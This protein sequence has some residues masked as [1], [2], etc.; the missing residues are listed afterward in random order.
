MASLDPRRRTMLLNVRV[1][2]NLTLLLKADL[3]STMIFR[4]TFWRR[5]R[6][7]K[8]KICGQYSTL[9][10]NAGQSFCCTFAHLLKKS[11]NRPKALNSLKQ[12]RAVESVTKL[13][14]RIARKWPERNPSGYSA[15]EKQQKR[16]RKWKKRKP[17]D[18]SVKNDSF[19]SPQKA[20]V[21]WDWR[22]I[23]PLYPRHVWHW[24]AK[25][26][27]WTRYCLRSSGQE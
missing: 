11:Q 12:K 2:L 26:R 8:R 16:G 4:M 24:N 27:K 7:V 1:H 13:L 10:S 17:Q 6:R 25:I 18:F 15:G 5:K 21:I 20:F 14:I 22:S 23:F 3:V 19:C 9:W